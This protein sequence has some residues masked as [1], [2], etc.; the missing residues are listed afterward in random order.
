MLSSLDHEHFQYL[1]ANETRNDG[2]TGSTLGLL[3]SSC[4]IYFFCFAENKQFSCLFLQ[5]T[6]PSTGGAELSSDA[7]SDK[8]SLRQPTVN[9]KSLCLDAPQRGV[10]WRW[11]LISKSGMRYPSSEAARGIKRSEFL[12]K[13]RPSSTSCLLTTS[14]GY[15]TVPPTRQCRPG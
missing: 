12:G 5:K 14:A 3:T 15:G 1:S 13:K 7:T 6:G 2:V 10:V 11:V 8:A 4:L 9:F